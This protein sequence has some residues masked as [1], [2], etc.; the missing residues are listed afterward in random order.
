MKPTAFALA[1]ILMTACTT[2]PAGLVERL[3]NAA[4][5]TPFYGHQ[6][7][8]MYGHEWNSADGIDSFVSC[9]S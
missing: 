5:T 7:D 6:D 2:K 8:L 3:S 1:L 9:C 4:E